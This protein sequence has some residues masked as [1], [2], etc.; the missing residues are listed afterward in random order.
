MTNKLTFVHKFSSSVQCVVRAPDE[1]PKPGTCLNLDFE[2]TGRLKRKHISDYRRWM[3][4]VN[5]TLSDNWAMRFLYALGTHH[6]R[7]E[8]WHFEP[9]QTPRLVQKLNIGIS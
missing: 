9:G 7:T 6:N 2:W 8:V 3:L 1:S 4:T 5:Q